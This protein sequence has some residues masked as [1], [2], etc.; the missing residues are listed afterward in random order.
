MLRSLLSSASLRREIRSCVVR[1][2]SGKAVDV[3]DIS[4][5]DECKLAL[6]VRSDLGMSR[7]KM[8]AQAAHGAVLAVS[9]GVSKKWLKQWLA[10]GQ[11]KIVLRAENEEALL[12]VASEAQAAALPVSLVRDAG[13]TQID[14]GTLTV[15][16]VGPAPAAAVDAITSRLKLL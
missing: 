9:S 7:G 6:I 4:Q 3:G 5:P 13:R 14:A 16:A 15:A 8:A 1:R 11:T 2:R 10:M 12:R